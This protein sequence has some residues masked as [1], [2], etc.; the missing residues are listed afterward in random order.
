MESFW[1]RRRGLAHFR[2][3]GPRATRARRSIA[4]FCGVVAC[5]SAGPA[6][7]QTESQIR[8]QQ[9]ML[10]WTTD[11]EGRIDGKAGP[12]TIEAIKKFQA[13]LGNPTTGRLTPAEEEAL[14][15]EGGSK[16]NR[17]GWEQITDSRAGVSVGLPL[18]FVSGP[19]DTKW[20][21]HWYSRTAGLAIDTLRFG[22]NTSLRQLYDRLISINNRQVTY[23][24]F[25]D[26]SWFVIAA[27]EKDSAVY[28]RADVVT[29]P[30]Q[31]SEI[32]GFSIWMSKD[33]PTDYQAIPPAM[34][35]SFRSSTSTTPPARPPAGPRA[36][37]GPMVTPPP[38]ELPRN[39]PPT[40]QPIRTDGPAPS[41]DDCYRGLGP[42]CPPVLTYN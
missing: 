40:V 4:L 42:G 12:G 15:R 10:I 31:Q 29:L 39:P 41:I 32:R 5:L 1:W 2:S 23:Q 33:R 19:T 34:L 17:A 7:G 21:K 38:P 25:V 18:H 9:E 20:G 36:E 24:R 37:G 27:F 16:K 6:L 28:V 26:D 11:Y 22:G 3:T 30:N 8:R 13:R 14:S 35:S